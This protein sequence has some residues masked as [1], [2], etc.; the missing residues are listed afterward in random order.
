MSADDTR[1]RT[2]S[3]TGDSDSGRKALS[4]LPS[5][6]VLA[7]WGEKTLGAFRQLPSSFQLPVGLALVILVLLLPFLLGR[8]SAP[9]GV[10]ARAANLSGDHRDAVVA[11]ARLEPGEGILDVSAPGDDRVEEILVK[12]GERVT[13]GQVLARGR[14]YALRK[15]EYELLQ[16]RLEETERRLASE[17]A[18]RATVVEQARLELEAAE[19]LRHDVVAREAEVRTLVGDSAAAREAAE[20]SA[21]LLDEGLT[22]Q[23]AANAAARDAERAAAALAEARAA[24]AD[25]RTRSE[26]DL[27]KARNRLE[28]ARAEAELSR[29]S[30]PLESLRKEL[31]LA[32]ASLEG[33]LA[34]A[35]VDAQ[36]LRIGVVPGENT[37]GRPIMSLGETD[38]MYAVAEVY[39]ADIGFLEPGQRVEFISSALSAPLYGV[40]EDVGR[41]IQRN[42]I[43]GDAPNSSAD[44]RVFR[45]RIR[46]EDSE[47]ASRFTNLEV[48]A[49]IFLD[50]E[51]G[52]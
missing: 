7:R 30:I 37:R 35:P 22:S 11:L 15:A 39:Q 49:R 43:F 33:A 21:G 50:G 26:L 52:S 45:V 38:R 20:L 34:R 44:A 36:V 27:E 19:L 24:L 10:P 46:L 25:T 28:M 47:L 48:E 14:Q 23:E 16:T 32:E 1:G 4:F 13:A 42:D 5:G 31:A 8:A 41:V 2:P 3:A 17:S 6:E 18:Y 12:E 51:R 40:V 9:T 29:N